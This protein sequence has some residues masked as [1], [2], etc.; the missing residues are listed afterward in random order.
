MAES[1]TK[2]LKKFGRALSAPLGKISLS[3]EQVV[4]VDLQVESITLAKLIYKKDWVIE[5][6]LHKSLVPPEGDY[7]L[8]EKTGFYVSH[9]RMMLI[10][11]GLMGMDGCVVLP[12]SA[13]QMYFIDMELLDEQTLEEYI[14]D[15]TLNEQ[16]PHLPK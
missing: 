1:A 5:K 12:H 8:T 11:Q 16:Y 4:A 13:S 14:Q 3:K 2:D 6:I 10:S 15:G 9:L 7:P